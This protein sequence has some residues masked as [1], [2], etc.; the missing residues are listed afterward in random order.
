M[1]LVIRLRDAKREQFSDRA[2]LII[3]RTDTGRTWTRYDF[4]TFRPI[5][6]DL[7]PGK[8]YK[9]KIF[10]MKHRPVSRFLML[11]MSGNADVTLFCPWHPDR[12]RTVTF[13][14]FDALDPGLKALLGRDN[15]EDHPQSGGALYDSMGDLQ[16]A[17]LL[18]VWT[19]M[20]HS[21]LGEGKPVAD[22]VDKLY[23]VRSDR[24]FA[25]VQVSL[26]DLVKTEQNVDR[27]EKVSGL[28]HTPPPG[29]EE[30]GSFKSMEQYGNLQLSFFVSKDPPLTFKVDADIDDAKGIEHLFQVLRN[31]ISQG[32]THPYDIH[33]ILVFH[34]GIDPGYSLEA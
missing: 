31:W 33:Q 3:E 32:A 29:F 4:S 6:A 2:D 10:P 25:N 19:K 22:Y 1:S 30:A 28:L 12:V 11:P 18:N 20:V 27:F 24:F 13:P 9:I 34:Q 14:S 17:G 16:K 7:E 26:R 23:R 8:V 15:V 5:S 21:V